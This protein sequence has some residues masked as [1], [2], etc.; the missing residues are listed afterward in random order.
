MNNFWKSATTVSIWVLCSGVTITLAVASNMGVLGLIIPFM[1]AGLTSM[2]I[3]SDDNST[4]QSQRPRVEVGPAGKKKRGGDGSDKMRLL[5]ELMDEDE[6]EVF[7]ETLKR[8]VLRQQGNLIDGELPY[9]ADIFDEY[10]DEAP[11]KR[12]RN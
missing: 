5:L 10:E 12:L 4:Q 11:P 3:W 8:Q 2:M 6:R 1:A 9:N 7:K